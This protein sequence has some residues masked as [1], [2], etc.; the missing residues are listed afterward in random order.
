MHSDKFCISSG[1]LIQ[2]KFIERL[3]RFVVKVQIG[4][5]IVLAHLPNPGRLWELLL[6]NVTVLIE[7]SN[8]DRS[9]FG[10]SVI[11]VMKNNNP[12]LLHT[13]RTNAVAKW[14]LQNNIIEELRDFKT[15]VTEKIFNNSRFD[16]YLS[17]KLKSVYLEVKSCT[18]FYKTLA[19][20]PDA[21]TTRGRRHLIELANLKN[22]YE[23]GVVLFLI[24]NLSVKYFLPEFHTDLEFSKTFYQN[25]HKIKYLA[26]SIEWD[27]SLSIDPSKVK[28]VNIPLYVLK[29][30]LEDKGAYILLIDN[31]IDQKIKIGNLGEIFFQKGF[32]CYVGSA[33]KNLTQRINRHKRKNKSVHWHIDYLFQ[34]SKI[35]KSIEIRSNLRIECELA[36]NL[37]RIANGKIERFGSSD[38]TCKSHLFYFISNPLQNEKFIEVIL[39][40]R[41]GKLI[42]KYNLI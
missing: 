35:I 1:E 36:L 29:N 31:Q 21:I 30:E 18:L 16:F 40:F 34:H 19:M 42:D 38:C 10:Y 13:I 7:K 32:Y 26:Y 5:E 28:K 39:D 24:H 6:P 9:K 17:N 3:N 33:M 23:E 20:F 2:G 22:K 14:L 12:I 27:N 15:I 8:I 41:I 11:G 37:S 4:Q 25:R